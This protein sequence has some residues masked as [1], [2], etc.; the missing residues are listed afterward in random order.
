M[1]PKVDVPIYELKLPSTGKSIRVRPFLVKEEKLLLMAVQSS[2]PEEIVK[3]T[4]QV[5]NN[6]LIDNDVNI[7][8]LPFFDIDYLFIALR[9]KSISEVIEMEFTCN[10]VVDDNKCGHVFE[11]N[12]DISNCRI[13]KNDALPDTFD[14]GKIK[15]KMKYPTYSV[16]KEIDDR[17]TTL[18]NKI[19]IITSCIDM[20]IDGNKVL[21][22][23]DYT[24]KEL[25]EFVE[26]LT[27]EHYKK[28]EI[29]IDN[30][31][32]FVV[33]LEKTCIKCNFN[34]KLEYNDFTSFFR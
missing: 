6:C 16:M 32:Y 15:V 33:D 5:I 14:L 28:L 9:A 26:N 3:T 25:V 4:K 22:A 17:A 10:N 1:L 7:E 29:F 18:D 23:K 2:E 8:S 30:F 19:R 11:A 13:K 20:V 24:K 34:H 21:T 12:V 31:P 27:E